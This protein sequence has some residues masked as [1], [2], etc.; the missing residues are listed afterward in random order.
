MGQ[1]LPG[2]IVPALVAVAIGRASIF[3]IWLNPSAWTE[4]WQTNTRKSVRRRA[5]PCR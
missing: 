4:G 1:I 2:S 5:D 3:S